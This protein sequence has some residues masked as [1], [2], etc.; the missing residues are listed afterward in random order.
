MGKFIGDT[1]VEEGEMTVAWVEVVA[2]MDCKRY[3]LGTYRSPGEAEARVMSMIEDGSI[4]QTDDMYIDTV[5]KSQKYYRR[6]SKTLINLEG[7]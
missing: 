3:Y 7:V 4:E 2:V 5:I 6:N 1:E